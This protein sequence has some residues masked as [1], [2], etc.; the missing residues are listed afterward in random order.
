M[1][2]NSVC[3]HKSLR[4]TLV[5]LC[6]IA[7]ASILPVSL[8]GAELKPF[9][10]VYIAGPDTFVKIVEKVAD[11]VGAGDAVQEGIALL[12]NLKGIDAGGSIGIALSSTEN[13][14]L[15]IFAFLPITDIEKAAV[16]GAEAIFDTARAALTKDG[17]GYSYKS[18]FGNYIIRQKKGYIVLAP[19]KSAASLPDD[20]KKLFAEFDKQTF[21]A[22]INFENTTPAALET[23]L[24]PAGMLLA[25]SGNEQ[26]GEAFADA[27]KQLIDA[28]DEFTSIFVAYLVDVNT[29]DV[30]VSAS[31]FA[32]KGSSTAEKWALQKNIKTAFSGFA[33]DRGKTIFSWI[34]AG[35]LTQKDLKRELEV[36]DAVS[37]SFAEGFTEGLAGAFASEDEDAAE[38]MTEELQKSAEKVIASVRKILEATLAKESLDNGVSLDADGTVLW[39]F[40]IGDTDE[41]A[42]LVQDVFNLDVFNLVTQKIVKDFEIDVQKYITKEYAEVA[43]YKIS[44]ISFPLKDILAVVGGDK[45]D[46]PAGLK[47]KTL[48]GFW[49][50]KK[51]EAV[52]VA[53]G[54]DAS[55]TEKTFKQALEKT[56]SPVALPRIHAVF[57]AKPLGKF[58][59]QFVL[60]ILPD[61]DE[62]TDSEEI[63]RM[64]KLLVEA[65]EGAKIEVSNEIKGTSEAYTEVKISG[66]L[67]KIVTE[68]IKTAVTTFKTKVLI[69]DTIQD[70]EP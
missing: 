51:N 14:E 7:F 69:R 61:A 6:I 26:A 27:Q 49:A 68:F 11:A 56:Q 8:C 22:K 46:I 70:V 35:V 36:F 9:L 25:L 20:P 64:T 4:N 19:E 48:N 43:G 57:S 52:A 62:D 28:F 12:K 59:Q 24:A 15:E 2:T 30:T 13:N 66:K 38:K 63:A 1:R 17:S 44:K 10:S 54:F 18:P 5:S 29:L 60:P 50:V 42:K 47:A 41:L 53:F 23:L 65:D 16:P 31:L 33:G 67:V 3:S 39:A 40:T 32:K 58:L 34:N 37:E 55:Q 45:K 21:G